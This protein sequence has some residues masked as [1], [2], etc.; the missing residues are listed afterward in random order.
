MDCP[1]KF[2]HGEKVLGVIPQL[3]CDPTA[4][5]THGIP[6]SCLSI[7]F[8]VKSFMDSVSTE[9]YK[10]FIMHSLEYQS[11][12]YE[13]MGN[14]MEKGKL[15]EDPNSTEP[16]GVIL[17]AINIRDLSGLGMEHCGL[18]GQE[19]SKMMIDMARDNYPEVL[20]KMIIV[21]SPW[22]FNG[23]WWILKA[24]LP[25]RTIDKVSINGGS[26]AAVL[27]KEVDLSSLPASLGGAL[28]GNGNAVPFEFDTSEGGLLWLSPENC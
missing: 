20:R 26:Y 10:T 8:S 13:Q 28:T 4:L 25:Q 23:L 27:A 19:I 3:L 9:E 11:V 16:Y 7:S 22:V 12:V 1:A 15:E 24:L 21:N 17:Q 2:P 6:I 18:K 14:A 5:D